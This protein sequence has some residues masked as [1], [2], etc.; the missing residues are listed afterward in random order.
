MGLR[1]PLAVCNEALKEPMPL[2][3]GS[4]LY[5]GILAVGRIKGRR[6]SIL[7]IGGERFGEPDSATAA[8]VENMVDEVQL[9][10]MQDRLWEASGWQDLLNEPM[11]EPIIRDGHC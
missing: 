6:K 5:Q 9:E 2:I 1:W 11:P 4:R 8:K 10:R 7:A 3:E